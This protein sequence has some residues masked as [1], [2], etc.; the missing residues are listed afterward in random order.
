MFQIEHA[1]KITVTEEALR[2]LVVDQIK[3]QDPS[4]DVTEVSFTAK[5]NPTTIEVTVTGCVNNGTKPVV[6]AKA[7]DTVTE[8]K[9]DKKASE[10]V[11]ETSVEVAMDAQDAAAKLLA[12][13]S[14]DEEVAEEADEFPA[15]DTE[16]D[17]EET[18]EEDPFL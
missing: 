8:T 1:I 15:E 3:R 2:Q 16:E 9:T 10:I 11:E 13:E 18:D 12:E 14:S 6:A 5:R 4:I 17:S 7:T